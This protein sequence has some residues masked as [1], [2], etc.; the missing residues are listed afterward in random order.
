MRRSRFVTSITSITFT[1]VLIFRL[2][3]VM[4]YRSVLITGFLIVKNF[5][6]FV[7]SVIQGG[8]KFYSILTCVFKGNI[9]TH[10]IRHK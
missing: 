3:V 4:M 1:D 5:W 10:M 9:T 7:S 8:H 6:I 2:V